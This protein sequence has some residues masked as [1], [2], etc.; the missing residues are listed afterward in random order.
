MKKKSAKLIPLIK[1]GIVPAATMTSA[2]LAPPVLADTGDLDPGFGDVGRLGPILDGP[3][4]SLQSLEDDSILLGGGGLTYYYYYWYETWYEPSNFVSLLS[5]TG[6]TDPNFNALS[7]ADTQFFDAAE[8]PDGLV[9]AVGRAFREP[10]TRTQLTIARMQADGQLDTAFA[11]Q[12]I[13]K[14][15]TVEHGDQQMGTSVV[16]DPDGR[17]VVAGSRDQQLIVLRL[18]PDGSFD[19]SFATSGVFVG[20]D[21]QDFSD[22][23]AGARTNLL[24][25]AGG[26]YRVTVSNTS[27]CQVVALTLDGTPDGTFGT[28]GVASVDAPSGPTTNCNAMAADAD[29]RLLLAGSAAGQAFVVR[30]LANGQPDASFSANAVAGQWTDATSVAA[31]DAGSVVVAGTGGNGAAIMR[32]LGNGSVDTSFGEVGTTLIDLQSETTTAAAVH[33]MLVTANGSVLAAGGEHRSNKAFVVK[34]LGAAGGDSPGVLGVADQTSIQTAEGNDEIVLNIR[35]SGGASGSVSLAY[36]TMPA[37]AVAGQDYQSV[38][39]RLTWA[40]GDMAVQQISVPILSDNAVEGPE[41]FYVTI[42]DI[43]GGAGLGMRNATVDIAADG[44]PFGQVS[45]PDSFV[46]VSEEDGVAELYIARN[47]FSSGA[48]SVT[49]TPIEIS[50]SAGTDFDATPLTVS[51]ADGDAGWQI[52]QIPLV[53]DTNAEDTERFSVELSNPTGG[54]ILGAQSAITVNIVSND[55]TRPNGAPRSGGGA[56]GYLSLLLL[57]AARLLRRMRRKPAAQLKGAWHSD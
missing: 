43:Q 10:A 34:L 9:V 46:N 49:L 33:D 32:L 16:V 11:N 15:S 8:Q 48:V 13:F 42:S 1:T 56:I 52:V 20:P 12:G 2:L 23:S 6:S 51:W 31:G 37:G 36:G 17:I 7:V 39:G 25:T 30:L 4:W 26:D 44:G 35:R 40:D 14:L 38:S 18:L 47:Y 41:S 57:G 27:G 19:D 22:G 21:T 29:G 53:N 5:S 28:A 24:R 55:Q 54:A 3:A 45:F 50:A